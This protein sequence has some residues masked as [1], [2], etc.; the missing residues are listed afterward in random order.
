MIL[1]RMSERD[2]LTVLSDLNSETVMIRMEKCNICSDV[3]P[4][5]EQETSF[6]DVDNFDRLIQTCALNL[7]TIKKIKFGPDVI[8]KCLPQDHEG[9]LL[10]ENYK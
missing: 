9:S 7:D 5:Q 8:P 1:L 3:L 2:W 6:G 10:G 4:F